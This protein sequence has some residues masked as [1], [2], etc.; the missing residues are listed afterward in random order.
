MDLHEVL[1]DFE[2]GDEVAIRFMRDKQEQTVD[3]ELGEN[4]GLHFVRD[5]KGPPGRLNTFHIQRAPHHQKR[6]QYR[7]QVH[8]ADDIHEE[9]QRLREH[10]ERLEH[11]L[12]EVEEQE[13]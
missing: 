9:L 2:P 13:G 3:V 8:E 12:Q 10:L 6:M 5:L 1:A 7:M 11:E 4:A